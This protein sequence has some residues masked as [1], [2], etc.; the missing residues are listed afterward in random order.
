MSKRAALFCLLWAG[1]L[2]HSTLGKA[3]V[4]ADFQ[5]DAEAI[6][7]L[8]ELNELLYNPPPAPSVPYPSTSAIRVAYRDYANI[9]GAGIVRN[10]EA[11]QRINFKNVKLRLLVRTINETYLQHARNITG[12]M[13]SLT[14]SQSDFTDDAKSL[15]VSPLIA[16]FKEYVAKVKEIAQKVTTENGAQFQERV[17]AALAADPEMYR[18]ELEA[19]QVDLA[20]QLIDLQTNLATL[21]ETSAEELEAF[22]T[23]RTDL[24]RQSAML[25]TQVLYVQEVLMSEQA[26]T[27]SAMA[28][29]DGI[30]TAYE[31]VARGVRNLFRLQSFAGLEID[32]GPATIPHKRYTLLVEAYRD[33]LASEVRRQMNE[34]QGQLM[35]GHPEYRYPNVK[36]SLKLHDL[37]SLRNL[38][39]R[40]I[41]FTGQLDLEVSF[42]LGNFKD[43]VA[44]APLPVRFVHGHVTKETKEAM[45]QFITTK[46]QPGLTEIIQRYQTA[47]GTIPFLEQC[48]ELLGQDLS[49]RVEAARAASMTKVA[50]PVDIYEME[51]AK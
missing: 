23:K 14:P 49:A 25:S 21:R 16:L 20:Q 28:A 32:L 2:F 29:L 38:F 12:R 5:S 22:E 27:Q 48:M 46:L 50:E 43:R 7:Y 33:H 31:N 36:V 41:G 1:F 44:A 19:L 9:L 11:A 15:I 17:R 30:Q 8:V 42:E 37:K 35:Q 13:N 39:F 51:E 26:S 45:T 10:I 40:L 34:L 47:T 3:A 18:A 4:E 24:Q 6:S